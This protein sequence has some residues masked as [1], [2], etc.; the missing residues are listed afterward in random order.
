[1]LEWVKL[2]FKIENQIS[3]S[4]ILEQ[5]SKGQARRLFVFKHVDKSQKGGRAATSLVFS[6]EAHAAIQQLFVTYPPTENEASWKFSDMPASEGGEPKSQK[7][8]QR[9]SKCA[10]LMAKSDI[11]NQVALLSTRLQSMPTLQQ[12]LVTSSFA[13]SH[14]RHLLVLKVWMSSFNLLQISQE[15]A[16]LPIA[17]FKDEIT[18]TIE[19]NQVSSLVNKDFRFSSCGSCLVGL[20]FVLSASNKCTISAVAFY[21]VH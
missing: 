11:E 14:Q 18:S 6:A 8:N 21:L 7:S 20:F 2:V 3:C 19:K 9:V 17:K 15:R 12:V 16:K 13:V 4:A 1:M 10:S 5:C